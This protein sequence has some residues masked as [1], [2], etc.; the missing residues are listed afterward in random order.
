MSKKHKTTNKKK[1]TLI[2]IGI[3]SFTLVS[4][5]VLMLT[6]GLFKSE[7]EKKCTDGVKFSDGMSF[8]CDEIANKG[9]EDAFINKSIV[10][11]GDKIYEKGTS[12]EI[13]A[14]KD[15]HFYC[16][17]AEDTWNH[18]GELRCVVFKYES[19]GQSGSHFFINEKK[20][21]KTGFVLFLPN[22]N[23]K[24]DTFEKMYSEDNEG[25][26]ITVCGVITLYEGHPQIKIGQSNSSFAAQWPTPG[27]KVFSIVNGESLYSYRCTYNA[28]R[29][30]YDFALYDEQHPYAFEPVNF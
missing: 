6:S 28:Y 30:S 16:L 25:H 11:H 19:I 20:D 13:A 7:F 15:N 5:L 14:G 3:G 9:L 29:D 24:W 2:F 21:Y 1:L 4:L 22:L 8:S 12:D 23:A 10:K 27:S 26:L 18:I 17:S